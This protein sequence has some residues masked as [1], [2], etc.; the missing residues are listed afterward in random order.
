RK[1]VVDDIGWFD[2]R[3]FIYMEDCDFCRTMWEAGWPVYYVHDI[4]IK[5]AHTRESAKVPGIKAILKNKLSRIH[6]KSWMQYLWK[7]RKTHRFY[8]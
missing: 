8:T 3:Y 5:H 2:P 4:R 7:W 1:E 6:V